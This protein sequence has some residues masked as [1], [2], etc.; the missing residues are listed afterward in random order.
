MM[1]FVV[2]MCLAL[3]VSVGLMG[4][5]IMYYVLCISIGTDD[6]EKLVAA[7]GV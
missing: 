6:F 4:R 3:R 2:M 1:I 5:C 7:G